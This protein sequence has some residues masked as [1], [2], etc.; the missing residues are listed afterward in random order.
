MR[1]TD[2][3]NPV[4]GD[5]TEETELCAQE[6]TDEATDDVFDE[7]ETD[8]SSVESTAS[9]WAK[10]KKNLPRIAVFARYLLPALFGVLLTGLS[11]VDGVRF[12]MRGR[13][14]KMSL[15]AFYKNTL[16]SAHHYL[17]G[18]T[19]EQAN[20]FYGLLSGGA[21]VG[22]LCYLLALFFAVLA[23]V[24]AC[25]A[26]FSGHESEQSNRM[27]LIFK[28]V[29]P[30][31]ICLYCSCLLFLVPVL[32]PYYFA[33]V[34]QRFILM[35]GRDT[36]FVTFNMYLVLFFVFAILTLVLSLLTPRYERQKKMNMFLL[37]DP[38]ESME[39]EGAEDTTADET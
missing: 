5:I 39:N 8:D 14:M 17:A 34:G 13:A 33:G 24:T 18:A 21:I 36:V 26:F 12:Y 38:D 6:E 31:R 25:R 19:E 29:F 32:F 16:T 9:A 30:N 35:G 1:E 4:E 7:D 22:I 15:F 3:T 20:W 10:V 27:K 2:K 23:A 37:W 11:F 28:I